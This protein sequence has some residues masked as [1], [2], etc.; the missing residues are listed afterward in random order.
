MNE[1]ALGV[2]AQCGEAPNLIVTSYTQFRKLKNVLE[3]LKY[4]P[5]TPRDGLAQKAQ[6]GFK[7]VEFM[8][9]GGPIAIVPDRRCPDDS[10][11][12]LNDNNLTFMQAGPAKWVDE[13]GSVLFRSA[14]ADSFEARYQTYG[15]LFIPPA[16]H[17]ILYNLAL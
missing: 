16:Y 15:E 14:S 4:Y 3:D 2:E 8:S 7:G 11:L 17:G 9:T 5:I 12:F 13:D 6:I 1:V 10:M